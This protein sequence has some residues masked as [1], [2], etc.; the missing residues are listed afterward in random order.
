MGQWDLEKLEKLHAKAATGEMNEMLPVSSCWL[1][2]AHDL[3]MSGLEKVRA[4]IQ[5]ISSPDLGGSYR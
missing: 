3:K 5:R 4:R 1:N 2:Q